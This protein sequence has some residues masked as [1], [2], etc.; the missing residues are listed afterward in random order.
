MTLEI[1]VLTVFPQLFETFR[2]TAFVGQARAEGLATV[3]RVE[4]RFYRSGK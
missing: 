4:V 2:D 1:Q 3:E